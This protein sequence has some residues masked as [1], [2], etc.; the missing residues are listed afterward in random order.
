MASGPSPTLTNMDLFSDID[1]Q[2]L[3]DA[4]FE[5][6]QQHLQHQH[7]HFH[8]HNGAVHTPALQLSPS[9]Q[10]MPA[11]GAF[12]MQHDGAQPLLPP[13]PR[14]E[15]HQQQHQGQHQIPDLQRGSM[16]AA[17]PSLPD[18]G[19][20]SGSFSMHDPRPQPKLLSSGA[21]FPDASAAAQDAGQVQPMQM[22]LPPAALHHSS[23][24]GA[25]PHMSPN[26]GW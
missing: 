3:L 1:L 22:P 23:S 7:Q 12:Q 5:V 20:G 2:A 16:T 24:A 10:G 18:F 11:I 17:H 13:H 15:Q 9:L 6:Q 19:G 25:L 8:Q 14:Q 26:S 4:E 21:C